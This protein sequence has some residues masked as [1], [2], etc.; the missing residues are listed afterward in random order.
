MATVI[1]IGVKRLTNSPSS[2]HAVFQ[3]K[4]LGK[5][6]VATGFCWLFFVLVILDSILIT[7]IG[8]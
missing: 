8:L 6:L 1:T 2:A 5:E 4:N 7:G 3:H